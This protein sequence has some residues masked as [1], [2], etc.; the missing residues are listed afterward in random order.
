MKIQ[1]VI[2]KTFPFSPYPYIGE[3]TPQHVTYTRRESAGR[4]DRKTAARIIRCLRS[5]GK[6]YTTHAESS[7]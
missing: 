7:D 4:F 3:A 6:F 1:T 5:W 2:L